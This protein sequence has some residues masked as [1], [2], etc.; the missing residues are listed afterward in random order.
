MEQPTSQQ[1]E[2]IIGNIQELGKEN[3][4][5]VLHKLIGGIQILAGGGH[6]RIYLED[7]TMGALSCAAATNADVQQLQT[8]FSPINN[9]DFSISQVYQQKHELDINDLAQYPLDFPL[10]AGIGKSKA[11]YLLP[12]TQLGRS[13]GVLC[14][15]RTDPGQLPAEKQ[16]HRIRKLLAETTPMLNSARKYYQQLQ[17]ARRVDE[18]KKREAALFMVKSA[19]QL[20][21]QVALAS[22][23]IPI[24][25][26]IDGERTL[27]ILASY[28]KEREA[29]KL[30]EEEKLINL[31]PGE[32]LLSRFIDRAGVIVDDSLL[33]PLY[34]SDLAAETLQKPYLTEELGLKSLYMVPRYDKRTR[35]VICLVNYYTKEHYQFSPFERDL[36]DAHAEMAQRVVQEIGDEHLEVQVLA[37][38]G[39]LLQQSHDNLKPFLH[40]VLSKATQLIGADTGSI[41]LIREHEGERWLL[42][43]DTQG[44]LIGAK[45]RDWLKKY[46]PPI[47]VGGQ[48]LPPEERSLSGLAAT[49]AK[50]EILVDSLDLENNNSFYQ[51]VTEAIRSEIAVPIIYDGEV[52]AV[53]C[54]DSLRPH[55]F[56][57]EHRRILLIIERM[58]GHHLAI[59]QKIEQL[60]SEIDRLRQDV[61]YKDP[62]ITSYRLGNI[63][64]NSTKSQEIIDTIQKISPPLCQRIVQWKKQ[65]VPDQGEFLGL[66]SILI[67]GE[68]G[69]GKEFLFNNLFTQ[70]N[71]IYRERL[72]SQGTLPLKKTNIA[73]YSGELTYSEL[74]GHKRGAFT[75]AH[76]DRRGIFEEA[77]GGVVFLDEIGDA[78]PKTQVQLLRF[79]DSGEFVRLGENITRH[80]QVLLVAGTNRDLRQLIAAGSFRE[81]LYYRLSELIIEVPSLNQRREDIPDLAVHFLGRLFQ[82]YQQPEQES[83][84]VPI[85]SLEA[86]NLLKHHHYTGNIRELRSILLRAML[87]RQG[88]IIHAAEIDRALQPQTSGQTGASKPGQALLTEQLAEDILERISMD[89][90]DFWEAI[91]RPYAEQE[92]TRDVVLKLVEKARAEGATNMPKLARIL[93]ACD[94][95]DNSAEEKKNFYRFKN[96]LYKTVRIS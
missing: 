64:G 38:I 18:A 73:A 45:N 80:S 59:L 32:S 81:D 40:R 4:E 8:I 68:T 17:L 91:Y 60:T 95:A 24:P 36:L 33:A 43:E 71:Q 13:I 25:S 7:L 23:L 74:F 19:A 49:T 92:L 79:L 39:D 94:P 84:E 63:I 20:V 37:E 55:Y 88:K 77:H 2:R 15:D 12:I 46:I 10:T 72:P 14:L 78:D 47:R 69:A 76:S 65:K 51:P 67:T 96:F 82:A 1:I 30:Y 27:Q 87:F 9:G 70:L 28:S 34:I 83:V 48:E 16:L 89:Q 22:V 57:N 52:L 53:I 56:T 90:Q 3:L 6:C 85:L 58:I 50:A 93:R 54:L 86:K 44:N 62:N 5:E 11:S 29:R 31:T 35:R 26:E 41:S 42:V 75:G 61:D 66:P 21:D